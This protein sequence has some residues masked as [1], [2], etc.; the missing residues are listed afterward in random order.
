[1]KWKKNSMSDSGM[2]FDKGKAPLH[3]IPEIALEGMAHAFDYG[4]KKYDRFNYRKGI[5]ITRLTDSL[6]RHTLAYLKGED[7]D[8]ESGLPHT[9]HMLANAAMIE[10][11][12]V[13]H[14]NLDDRY[15]K[16][17]YDLKQIY[18]GKQIYKAVKKQ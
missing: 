18:P 9:W 8:P 4:A 1:M 16:D 17:E 13:H 3:M 10:W 14:P 12:R 11:T 5:D 2:K 15:K 7:N 6:R